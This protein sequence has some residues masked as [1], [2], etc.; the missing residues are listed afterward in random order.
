MVKGFK[1]P[2]LGSRRWSG[3]WPP[4][5]PSKCM[6]PLRAFWPLPPRPAV[7][8]RPEPWPRPTRFLRCQL[9]LGRRSVCRDVVM[10][11]VSFSELLRGLR[12]LRTG[13][14]PENVLPGLGP[15]AGGH[16]L[17]HRFRGDEVLHLEDHPANRR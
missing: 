10:I 4:S 16:V 15:L 2:R 12:V 14:L 3:L 1:K 13:R 6:L 8:P 11:F 5:K 7:L 17:L 9:P